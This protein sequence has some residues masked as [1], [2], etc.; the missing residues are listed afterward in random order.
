MTTSFYSFFRLRIRILASR[1]VG[2][3]LVTALP[4]FLEQQS[5]GT[6]TTSSKVAAERPSM[7]RHYTTG[8]H[9]RLILADGFLKPYTPVR[10]PEKGIVYFTVRETYEPTAVKGV[11]VENVGVRL[12]TIE[13]ME[14][15]LDGLYRIGVSDS[16]PLKPWIE[17]NR[18][19]RVPDRDRREM[20]RIACEK[21]S[22]PFKFWGTLRPVPMKDWGAVEKFRDGKW[23]R[24][25][26][27]ELASRS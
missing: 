6:A 19:A 22:D 9:M 12:L 13:E 20:E 1:W 7:R 4:I 16:Y 11:A 26:L 25:P 18:L 10:P 14:R 3:A 24:V 23:V 17:I 27:A 21:G 2:G 5:I 15:E 8:V